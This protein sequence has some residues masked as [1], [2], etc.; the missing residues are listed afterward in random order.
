MA[1]TDFPKADN[2][3]VLRPYSK[4]MRDLL[5]RKRYNS[6]KRPSEHTISKGGFL[7]DHGGSIPQNLFEMEL[8]NG[9][10]RTRLPNIFSMS[11]TT[12][13]DF[14]LRTCRDRKITPHPAR[15]PVGLA[16]F[17]IQFLTNPGDLVLDPFAGSN[18]TGFACEL[19]GRHWISI[20]IKKLYSQQSKIR[21]EDPILTRKG[22]PRL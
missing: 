15:M 19:L 8:L 2:Q 12:S 11:N 13:N 3:K 16:A 1:K 21:F 17:F 5:K 22:D 14:F 7:I 10:K 4:S 6:G 20:E 18:T 9:N